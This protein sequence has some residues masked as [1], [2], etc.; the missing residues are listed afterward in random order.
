MLETASN[1]LTFQ[2]M[3]KGL[4]ENYREYAVRW[5]N[6]ASLVQSPLTNRE[7][8]SIF[9]DTLPS[10]YYNMLVVN[11]FVEFGDLMYSVGRI[12]DGI[13][14]GKIVEIGASIQEK[15]MII[16]N[17]HNGGLN[18]RKPSAIEESV[19]NLSRSLRTP[20]ARVPQVD[21]PPPQRF[22]R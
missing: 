22:T 18:K 20:Y 3:K 5:K 8:N 9:V 16:L 21:L 6:V 11:A 15:K 17:E 2:S 10:L 13:R 7:K 12:K 1:R 14:R 19:G 4:E